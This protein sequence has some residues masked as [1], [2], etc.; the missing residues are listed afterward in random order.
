MISVRE[1]K[2]GS[3]DDVARAMEMF[4]PKPEALSVLLRDRVYEKIAEMFI[5]G[6]AAICTV[7]LLSFA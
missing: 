2:K 3:T 6:I 7:H 1:F 5:K 4:G